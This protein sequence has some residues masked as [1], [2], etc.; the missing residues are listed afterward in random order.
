MATYAPI[1]T[2][3]VDDGPLG[4]LWAGQNAAAQRD[5]NEM[6]N[7]ADMM[8]M[9]TKRQTYDQTARMD[10]ERLRNLQ[11]T[12]TGLDLG[13]QL[14]AGKLPNELLMSR[15]Q[16]R[17][18]QTRLNTPN[19]FEQQVAGGMA[20]AQG[21][22]TDQKFKADTLQG[23]V[24]GENVT[25][26]GKQIDYV[27]SL[28]PSMRGMNPMQMVDFMQSRNVAPD[29]AKAYLELIQGK[30]GIDKL[31]DNMSKHRKMQRILSGP[32]FLLVQ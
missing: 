30:G 15:E 11:F 16:G 28:L 26:Q 2:G 21:K 19:W 25:N 1:P 18:A 22:V 6:S 32:T 4:A 23:R 31:L 8:D 3:Y 12:N 10:P 17:M 9:L 7:L 13:N 20:E 24:A 27:N 14:S 29:V 5:Q